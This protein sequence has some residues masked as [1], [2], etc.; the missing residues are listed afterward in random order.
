MKAVLGWH[1]TG[2]S[3]F[4]SH[5][6][7]SKVDNLYRRTAQLARIREMVDEAIAILA[8]DTTPLEQVDR[9]MDETW[10]LKRTLSDQVST[11][12]IDAVYDTAL[13]AGAPGG[14][15]LGVAAAGSWRYSSRAIGKQPYVPH[16]A[17]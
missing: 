3:R 17:R 11:T 1:F 7:Q 8:S 2:I 9:L 15:V 10:K 4:S 5:V 12:H 16:L 6:A 13:R 14:K